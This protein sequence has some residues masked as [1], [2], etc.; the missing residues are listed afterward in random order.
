MWVYYIED[1]P[2]F[3][4]V[5]PLDLEYNPK[6]AASFQKRM[7][8]LLV[9]SFPVNA[10]NFCAFSL[11]HVE[12][13]TAE[14][15]PE[16]H[17]WI[18]YGRNEDEK[19]HYRAINEN[20]AAFLSSDV[21]CSHRSA[22]IAVP[23]T[24]DSGAIDFYLQP[25][26]RR[27]STIPAMHDRTAGTGML[28]AVNV[29]LS[30][31]GELYAASAYEDGSVMIF[32]CR[33]DFRDLDAISNSAPSASW[34]WDRIYYTT[35]HKQPALSL[36]V[37]H[38]KDYFLTSAADSRIV[39]HPIPT[40]S[41]ATESLPDAMV[42]NPIQKEKTTTSGQQS[43]NIRDDGLLFATACWDQAFRVYYC[44]NL[45]IMFRLNWHRDGCTAVAFGHISEHFEFDDPPPNPIEQEWC[46]SA[47][48]RQRVLNALMDHWLVVGSKDGQISLWLMYKAC[49]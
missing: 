48:Q 15:E 47:L 30:N 1:E 26:N 25:M 37:S 14:L 29:F 24:L 12:H 7:V 20:V 21:S 33:D 28:M 38:S 45:S 43:L 22:L 19:R 27:V 36:A 41:P 6:G 16:R 39:K 42:R 49:D 13:S 40:P 4:K 11:L 10:L 3:D 32:V 18:K 23:N 5:L 35:P 34:K 2:H 44:E 8:P 17:N 46:R 9:R 31:A